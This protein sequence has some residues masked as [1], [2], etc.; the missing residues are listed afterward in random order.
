[1]QG[2]WSPGGLPGVWAAVRM[3]AMDRTRQIAKAADGRVLTFAEWGDR[4]GSPVFA[5]HGTPGCRLNRH[6]N[7]DLVRSAGVRL[8]T[9]D[10]AGYGGSD[11]HRGRMVADDAGDVA[12]IADGLGIERFAVF[13]GSGGGPHALAVAALLGDRV[14]RAACVVGVAPFEA[15]GDDFFTGMDPENV[16]EFGWALE[17]EDRLAAELELLDQQLRQRAAADPASILGDFQLSESDKQALGRE[18]LAQVLR[19]VVLEQTRNG[20]WG[21]VDDDLAFTSSW[22]FDPASI[23][24]PTQISYGTEDVLVPVRH[25]EWIA[26]TVPG[27]VV[28]LS[29]LGHFGDPDADLVE[30]LAW[31]TGKTN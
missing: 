8:I 12:A 9:Y 7:E 26:R 13:G 20:V 21:W 22:G 17:G 1:M 5:L 4:S 29:E 27:A 25:G 2:K 3:T 11:R 18:D 16:K 15:L 24:V 28:K 10:R 6:P 14:I 19:E 23:T 31:L 30:R